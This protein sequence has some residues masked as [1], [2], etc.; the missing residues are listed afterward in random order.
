[1]VTDVALGML[2]DDWKI[3][4]IGSDAIVKGRI[5]WM[6]YKKTD[7]RT[8]GPVVIGGMNIKSK[9][10]LDL[11][12][13]KYIAREK[14]E[15]APNIQLKRGDVLLVQRGNGVG[16][17]AYFDGSIKEATINPTLIILSEFSGDPKFLFYYLTSPQGRESI[18]ALVSGSSIPALYQ[19]HVKQLTYPKPSIPEQRAIAGILGALDDKIELNRRMNATLESMAR[20]VFR[21]WFV[22][23]EDVGNYK[24]GR[25]GDVVKVNER[26][27][28]KEYPNSEIEYIDI[29]SVATGHLDGTTRYSLADAPSRARRLVKHG[30]TIWS[31][32]RPN[33]KSF[34]F[35]SK[36]KENLVVSTGFAVLTPTKIPPSLLYF[37][38]TT[39]EFVDYLVSNADGSA[40]PAVLPERFAEAEMIMPPKEILDRFEN[41]AGSML[42]RIAHNENESRTLASLRDSLLPRLMRGEVRVSAL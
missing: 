16:D 11:S 27:I 33:R 6:G 38:V 34:L 31:T 4:I 12:D 2:P 8:S 29:S 32:V 22:E 13:I 14:Y 30:D 42:A 3:G 40:Y 24:I 25:L 5:G 10:Y 20:A 35:I 39:N 36:P 7:L 26:S 1:M 28:T 19:N 23:R 37:W 41:V 9:L 18:L 15:E 21:Q 17:T